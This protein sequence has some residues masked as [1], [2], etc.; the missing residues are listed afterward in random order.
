VTCVWTYPRQFLRTHAQNHIQCQEK[1]LEHPRQSFL[2]VIPEDWCP[3]QRGIP[4]EAR[5]EGGMET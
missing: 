1:S 4:F 5:L 2:K 3:S